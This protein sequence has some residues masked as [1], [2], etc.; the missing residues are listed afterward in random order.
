MVCFC[1]GTRVA[2]GSENPSGTRVPAAALLTGQSQLIVGERKRSGIELVLFV[3]V[4]FRK[5]KLQ[6]FLSKMA[7]ERKLSDV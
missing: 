7:F 2:A 6:S 4:D 1:S 3:K 5:K